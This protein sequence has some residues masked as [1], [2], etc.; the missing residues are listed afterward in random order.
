M[1]AG[2]PIVVATCAALALWAA[3]R[4]WAPRL[5]GALAV[6]LGV[7]VAVAVMTGSSTPIDVSRWFR[8]VAQMTLD[9]DDPLTGTAD[10][11]WSFFPLATF[12]LVA[13]LV[14]PLPWIVGEKMLM[15]GADLAVVWLVGAIARNDG[16]RRRLAYALSPV[17]AVVSAYHGQLE[18]AALALALGALL[19]ARRSRNGLSGALFGLAVS[20]KT[21]PAL[22]APALFQETERRGRTRAASTAAIV[23]LGQLAALP[24]L[25]DAPVAAL[26]RLSHHEFIAGWGW[27]AIVGIVT[28][29][30]SMDRWR[31]LVT[32]G[33]VVLA[34][35]VV[36][37]VRRAPQI[38]G[39]G[40]AAMT[41]VTFIATTPVLAPQYL[42]W[43]VPFL[44]ATRALSVRAAT[45]A[46]GVAAWMLFAY[47]DGPTSPYPTALGLA[48]LAVVSAA[49]V[50]ARQLARDAMLTPFP[51]G[52]TAASG[53]SPRPRIRAPWR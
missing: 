6:G 33:T 29:D 10:F 3:H 8:G 4:R 17:A 7:R 45:A 40:L 13:A 51:P 38:D 30:L 32:V 48:S 37:L 46:A 9:G 41:L 12:V 26:R 25:S 34:G 49:A 47:A 50:M 44:L 19:A 23:V 42:V 16:P 24:L 20:M 2:V 31:V 35:A 22:L 18:P 39:A 1:P 36:V 21:W 43:P 14:L 5:A 53:S 27:G 15:I 11:I 28:P 52:G